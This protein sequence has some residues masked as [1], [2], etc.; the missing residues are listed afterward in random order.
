M[1]ARLVALVVLMALAPVGC[2]SRPA[3]AE[4]AGPAP[5]YAQLAQRHNDRLQQLQNT[6]SMGVVEFNWSDAR[7]KHF[8]QG[9]MDLWISLPRRTALRMNKFG[10]VLLWL[11]SDDS[12]W[13][14]F[15]M[16]GD[17]KKLYLGTH[18]DAPALD[19]GDAVSVKPLALLDLMAMTPLPPDLPEPPA[20]RFESQRKAWSVQA[21]GAGSQR[22][23]YFDAQSWLPVA[24]DVLDDG[25]QVIMSSTLRRYESVRQANM[26]VPAFP[27]MAELIDL[28]ILSA[29]QP[30][31][32]K[33]A[34]NETTGIVDPSTLERVV[35]LD[36]LRRGMRVDRVIE[37]AR[38]AAP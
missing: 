6:H 10:E 28:E 12:R 13:W 17:E 25:G 37:P 8:A 32:V 7:G 19:A 35:D 29:Q 21:P 1:T 31:S 2:K 18:D 27:R 26:P 34:I 16:L 36:R 20:V 33:I 9:D 15:D 24:V 14:V 23:L 30:A 11:G 5:A 38:S 3:A 22:R 4:P